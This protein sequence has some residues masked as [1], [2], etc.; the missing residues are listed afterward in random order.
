MLSNLE[1]MDERIGQGCNL[2]PIMHLRN[3]LK[4]LIAKLDSIHV[5]LLHIHK[6]L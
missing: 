1:I 5:V 3:F 6:Y 2:S 4:S